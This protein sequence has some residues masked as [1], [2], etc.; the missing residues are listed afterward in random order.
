MLPAE[1]PQRLAAEKEELESLAGRVAVN[2]VLI[3]LVQWVVITH[4]G[5]GWVLLAV[6]VVPALF[7][8]YTLTRALTVTTYEPSRRRGERR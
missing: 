5:D 6:L 1:E 8:S 4:R 7:A 3:V 2:A